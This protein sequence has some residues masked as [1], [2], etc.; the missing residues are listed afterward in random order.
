MALD[1]IPGCKYSSNRNIAQLSLIAWAEDTYGDDINN[2][3]NNKIYR[4]V[5]VVY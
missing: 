4:F 5:T 3:N 2:S 1:Q